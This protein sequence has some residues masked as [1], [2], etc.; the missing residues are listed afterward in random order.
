MV[1]SWAVQLPSPAAVWSAASQIC[2]LLNPSA[3]HATRYAAPSHGTPQHLGLE[4]SC[5]A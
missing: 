2:T 5:E 4:A 3:G 1:M